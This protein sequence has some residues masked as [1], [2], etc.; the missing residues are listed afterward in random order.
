MVVKNLKV[1]V[2]I[3]VFNGEATLIDSIKSI[4]SQTYKNLEIL[5]ID[6][7]SDDKTS[8]ICNS[9]EKEDKRITI[10]KNQD[11][12]GL[13]KSLNILL[14]K[15]SGTFIARH[16]IDDLSSP[17]RIETQLNF[18]LNKKVDFVY[19]RAQI[20]KSNKLIPGISYFLP[21]KIIIKFKNPFIHGTLFAKKE[22]ILKVGKYDERFRYSQDYKLA[23]DLINSGFRVKVIKK[24]LYNLNMENNISE[25]YKSQQ[26]YYADCVRKHKVPD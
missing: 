1:S 9:L 20:I 22:I 7:G 13:T 26:A 8:E 16:D 19:S 21:K 18:L 24:P 15:S 6:D 14:E 11:N 2:L 5:I 3:A 4:T 17:E 23:F 25:K 10:Y 12:I